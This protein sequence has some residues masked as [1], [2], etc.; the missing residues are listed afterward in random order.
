M[1][2]E[3]EDQMRRVSR[4]QGGPGQPLVRLRYGHRRK[5]TI[6]VDTE[7][8]TVDAVGTET[9]VEKN[10]VALQHL[11]AVDGRAV[12]TGGIGSLRYGL[13]LEVETPKAKGETL[14]TSSFSRILGQFAGA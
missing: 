9:T 14:G 8:E 3:L 5:V 7:Q 1:I 11:A 4:V 10:V 12:P 6:R 13:L 2:V